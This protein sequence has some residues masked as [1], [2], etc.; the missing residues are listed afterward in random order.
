M[1][2]MER[3]GHGHVRRHQTSTSFAWPAP[4]T[5]TLTLT[6]H[7]H[8]Y[9]HPDHQLQTHG[10]DHLGNI[11]NTGNRPTHFCMFI[12]LPINSENVQGKGRSPAVYNS[13]RPFRRGR[14]TVEPIKLRAS[15][16]RSCDRP[17][18]LYF[19]SMLLCSTE[20]ATGGVGSPSASS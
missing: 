14:V 2:L 7:G 3:R 9:W 11:A 12:G 8:Q 1:Q 10:Q 6:G 17:R 5:V 15:P 18:P 19:M 13:G 4:A 16:A 20:P